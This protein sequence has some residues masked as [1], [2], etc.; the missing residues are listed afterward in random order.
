VR[1]ALLRLCAKSAFGLARLSRWLASAAVA[2]MSREER[3]RAI[4]AHWDHRATAPAA[5]S[6]YEWERDFYSKQ[7]PAGSRVLLVGCGSGRDLIGLI[8]A[9]Y[10][11]DGLE[12]APRALALCREALGKH[13]LT[14]RLYDVALGEARLEPGYDAAVFT[15]QGY[16]LIPERPE[17]IGAL[18]AL[19]AGLRP[20]GRVLLTCVGAPNSNDVVELSAA[21]GRFLLYAEH[22]F[23]REEIASEAETAGLRVAS[24]ESPDVERVVLIA[25]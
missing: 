12:I 23:T 10:R 9:G 25:D 24:H 20:G 17:R 15:W 2:A 11:A 14:A 22:R 3:R 1:A 4:V 16:G 8:R 5:A 6:L 18:Q 21:A 19:R 13:G 7:L